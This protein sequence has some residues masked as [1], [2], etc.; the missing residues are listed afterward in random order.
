MGGYLP[1]ATVPGDEGGDGVTCPHPSKRID[2]IYRMGIHHPPISVAWT[3]EV[4]HTSGA[5]PW[6]EATHQD[7][8]AAHM[9]DLSRDGGSEIVMGRG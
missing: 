6:A 4:C 2:G 1:S 8:I 3:C 9:V 5:T 7:R